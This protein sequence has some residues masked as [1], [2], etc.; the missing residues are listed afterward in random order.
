MCLRERPIQPQPQ[1][2]GRADKK[3]TSDKL[4]VPLA[5]ISTVQFPLWGTGAA[6]GLIVEG[7]QDS[8]PSRHCRAAMIS[9]F[10][11]TIT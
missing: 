6:G 4:L 7:G 1:T 10:I 3:T 9:F 11:T 2:Q 8:L 5:I